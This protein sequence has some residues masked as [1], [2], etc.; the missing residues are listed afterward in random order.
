M[1]WRRDQNDA[2]VVISES[3]DPR[4]GWLVSDLMRFTGQDSLAEL[5]AVSAR[6]LL[7]IEYETSRH[8]M[9][10]TNHLMA[11]NIPEPPNYLE[12]KRGIFTSLV[13]G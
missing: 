3:G 10:V 8:W 4:L 6:Q 13:P 12:L 9:E 5:L 11:W 2:L 1:L 7:D